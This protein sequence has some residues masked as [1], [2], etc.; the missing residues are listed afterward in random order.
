MG[1]ISMLKLAK[2]KTAAVKDTGADRNMMGMGIVENLAE[3][4]PQGHQTLNT[5]LVARDPEETADANFFVN[6]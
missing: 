3:V 1:V 6:I 4:V 5:E 2:R